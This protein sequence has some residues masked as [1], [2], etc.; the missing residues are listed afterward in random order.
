MGRDQQVFESLFANEFYGPREG[1]E[2]REWQMECLSRY[3][4]DVSRFREAFSEQGQHRF[5]LYAGTGSGK[6]KVAGLL[7]AFLLNSKLVDQVVFVCPNRSIRRKAQKDLKHFFNVHLAGF[8]A[9]KHRDGIPRA[10][11]GYILT[12]AHLM[13]D[14]TLHRRICT[15]VRTL[16]VFDEIHHL[17]DSN[18]WGDSAKEAFDRI[19]FV[20]GLSGTPYRSDNVVIPFVT[21]SDQDESGLLKFQADYTYSLGRAVSDGVCRDPQFIFHDGR[22]KIRLESDGPEIH[23]TFDSAVNDTIKSLRLRGAVRYN[24][25]TRR[26][27]L[28][29]AL[30]RC[31]A[32]GRKVIV[33]LGG[34]TESDRTPTEDA[35]ELLP[36]ELHDLGIQPHEYEV[37]TGDDKEAQAK[38]EAFGASEKWILVSINMVSEGTDIPELSAAIFLTSITAKQTTVQRIGRVL[39][40]QG[41]DDHFV[42]ALIFMF[43]DPD[44]KALEEEIRTEISQEIRLRK[45]KSESEKGGAVEERRRAESIGVEGGHIVTVKFHGMELPIQKLGAAR[46]DLRSRGLPSTMLFAWLKLMQ[47]GGGDV[48][49]H[50]S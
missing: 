34:D 18:G 25:E 49:S 36:L 16:V 3:M 30:E 2:P 11:E 1:L 35:R 28:A 20:V 31:R 38:I 27:M 42:N 26:G 13:Q 23:A 4:Q 19:P 32:E 46:E 24:A 48:H 10:I 33:F 50:A 29:A 21:Y 15:R 9:R 8:N 41:E 44:F 17:G 39:R 6:T 5:C 40:M 47:E 14:P 12:Y 37:I 22:V 43:G 45:T 7:M